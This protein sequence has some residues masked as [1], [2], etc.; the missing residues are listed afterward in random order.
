MSTRYAA[1]YAWEK[2]NGPGD[3]R[4]TALQIIRDEGLINALS[5]K[6]ILITGISS[7]IGIE[8]LRALHATGAH[9]FG[10]VRSLSKG[11]AVVDE[12][13]ASNP[14]GGKIDLIEMELSSLNSV[15][16][17][18]ADFLKKS[19]GKCN[20]LIANAGIMAVPEGKTVDGW[21]MQFGTNYLSHFL[22]FQLVKD[23]M[24][25]SASPEFPSRVVSVSS[26][27]HRASAI[28]FDD[29]NFE[30]SGYNKWVAYGQSKTGNIYL[31]NNV[32]RK[33]ATQNLYGIALHPGGIVTNLGSALSPEE[34]DGIA[35]QPDFIKIIESAEQGAA[36]SV[37]VAVG[38][39]WK[40]VGGV[41]VSDCQ[42]QDRSDGAKRP[43]QNQGYAEWAFDADAEEKLWSKSL[44][45]AGVKNV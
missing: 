27:G 32:T 43:V 13:L 11:Q 9:C 22:L 3:D 14:N 25:S 40:T 33:Y 15:R 1:V 19:N 42:I 30:K 7:G 38:K 21:E 28:R 26:V 12:M 6:T 39:E 8:T 23:A 4:P 45:W 24:L 44:E 36:T 41:W 16:R 18:A 37:F 10:T 2:V 29:I 35:S 31:A 34:F 20:I 5:D 17:G